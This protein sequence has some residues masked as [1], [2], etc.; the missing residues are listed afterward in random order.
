MEG[1]SYPKFNELVIMFIQG[2]NLLWPMIRFMIN[3][4]L[5][6]IQKVISA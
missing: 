1:N 6:F 2:V 3:D 4:N 5:K